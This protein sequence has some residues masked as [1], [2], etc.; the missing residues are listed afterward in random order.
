M[1]EVERQLNLI[2]LEIASLE[3][4]IWACIERL[5]EKNGFSPYLEEYVRSIMSDLS[6]WTALC[7]TTSESPHVL[8][9]RMEVHLTRVRRLSKH[10]EQLSS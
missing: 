9:R 3:E 2:L 7:T 6:Y 5:H 10:L 4:R 1:E 8:L